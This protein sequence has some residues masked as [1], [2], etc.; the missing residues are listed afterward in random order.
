[1]NSGKTSRKES[2]AK[3]SWVVEAAKEVGM[4]ELSRTA[5]KPVPAGWSIMSKLAMEFHE[6]VFLYS[7]ALSACTRY[8]RKRG[9]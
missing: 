3:C 5:L 7:V 9:V 1:M 8:L 2:I 6:S 4:L